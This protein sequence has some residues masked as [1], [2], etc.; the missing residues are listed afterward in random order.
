MI[1][2]LTWK[3]GHETL[4]ERIKTGQHIHPDNLSVKSFCFQNPCL[5]FSFS[6]DF[7]WYFLKTEVIEK[8]EAQIRNKEN[9]SWK[10]CWNSHIMK[11]EC[12]TIIN[13]TDAAL[14]Q[15]NPQR[16]LIP[17]RRVTEFSIW[18]QAFW[19]VLLPYRLRLS[20]N[21]QSDPNSKKVCSLLR[22]MV[23]G[24]AE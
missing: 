20:S 24:N 21:L 15:R 3:G 9:N 7:R 16:D 5:I 14:F 11:Y 8:T 18:H 19:S 12:C 10:E 23:F 4:I 17:R 1:S 22:L 13:L 2:T 6:V